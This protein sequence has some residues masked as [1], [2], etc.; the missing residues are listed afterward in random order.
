MKKLIAAAFIGLALAA[1]TV[2]PADAAQQAI[3]YSGVRW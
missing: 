2:V 1:S 3:K